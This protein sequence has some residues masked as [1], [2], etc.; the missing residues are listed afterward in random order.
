[1][2]CRFTKTWRVQNN[3]DDEW[4]DG[5]CLQFTG[6]VQLSEC[7]RLSHLHVSC[8]YFFKIKLVVIFLCLCL[9]RVPVQPVHAGAITDLSVEMKSPSTPGIYQSKWRMV[10]PT[11]SYFGGKDSLL[12]FQKASLKLSVH[13]L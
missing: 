10:T 11:G 5:C 6:G 8:I 2:N 13:C 3:G 12:V 1:M 4:P 7:E 9:C